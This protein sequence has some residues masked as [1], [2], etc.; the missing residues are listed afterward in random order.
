MGLYE[1]IFGTYSSRELKRINPIVDQVLALEDK[2]SKMS[3]HQ[4]QEQTP[5]LKARLQNAETLDDI[6]PDAFAVC[7]EAAWRVLGM[8][9]FPYR[10]SAGSCSIRDGSLKCVPVRGKH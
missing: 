7:R 9:H 2:Y 4:L 1:K 8:K 10:S 3:D 6:L 5:V